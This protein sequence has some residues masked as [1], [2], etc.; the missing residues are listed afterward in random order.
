[1]FS[2]IKGGAK[3][4]TTNLLYAAIR[5]CSLS[6]ELI[7]Y[8]PMASPIIFC[9]NIFFNSSGV[10]LFLKTRLSAYN[11]S[12]ASLIDIS[13]SSL[14]KFVAPDVPLLFLIVKPGTIILAI[15]LLLGREMP[16]FTSE[17]L[18]S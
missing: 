16:T 1:M 8:P 2:E 17:E 11:L 18:R 7:E 14:K 12:Y 9:S 5:D 3:L 13:T 10:I 15:F 6:S 4:F